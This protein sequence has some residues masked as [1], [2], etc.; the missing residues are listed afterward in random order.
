MKKTVLTLVILIN[1]FL[2]ISQEVTNEYQNLFN[3]AYAQHQQI[4]KGMLEAVSFTQTHFKHIQSS[5]LEGCSG[6]PL[7]SGVMGLTDDGKGYFRSNLS[8]VANLSGYSKQTI[9]N[10]PLINILSYA[11]AYAYLMDSL[12]I[13]TQEINRHDLILKSLSEIP[14]DHNVGN[15][16]ALNSFVY[17]VFDFLKSSSKQSFYQFPNHNI[18]MIEL[19]GENNLQVL[20]SSQVIISENSVVNNNN[21]VYES[22]NRTSQYTPAIWVATPSCNYSSRSGTVISAVTIHTIQGSYSGAISWAQNC[23]A[24]VSY[25]YVERSSDGQ[26]TQMVLEE[27]K[28][29]HVGN[30][31]PYTIGIE[32]EGYVSDASWYTEA[33][34]QSSANLV[35]DITDSGYGINPLRT[36]YGTATSGINVLGGCTKIKG[37]Q[38]YPNNSHTDPG[39]NWNWEK[40]YKLINN[41]PIVTSITTATGNLFDSGGNSSNYSNDER[42]MYLIEPTGATSIT[43]SFNSFSVESG[44]DYMYIYD[45][46]NT[47]APLMGVYTGNTIPSTLTSSGGQ[48]LLEFRSDCATTDIGWDLS[49]TS[50]IDA[51]T[52]DGT[53]PTTVINNLPNW[54]TVDFNSSFTDADENGGSGLHYKFYQIVDYNGTDWLSNAN[55]GFFYDEFD[56]TIQPEWTQQTALWS[57]SNAYL[58]C[59]DETESNSNIYASLNQ[60]DNDVYVYNWAGKIKG[61]GTNKRAGIHFMCSDPTLNQRG[62]SYMVYFRTDNDK[63]Q[64]YESVSNS[65]SLEADIDFTFNED[66]WYDLK[67][68]YD[69][70]TGEIKVFVD[71]SL[72]ASW[73]DATPISTGN[74]ISLRSGNCIYQINNFSVMH[75]RT[76]SETVGV[77]T[78]NEIRYQN[79]SPTSPSGLIKSMAIDSAGNISAIANKNVNLDWTNPI[80]IATVNDGDGADINTFTN[81]NSISAN[82]TISTDANSDISSY[83][84][85]IGTTSGG[86]DIVN[87]TDNWYNTS[88]THSGLSLTYGETYYVSIKAENGAGLFSNITTSNGHELITPTISPTANFIVPYTTLCA[89]DSMQLQNNSTDAETY[90]WTISSDAIITSPTAVNPYVKFINSG[91]FDISL[92]VTGPGGTDN[93]LQTI[94]VTVVEPPVASF[95]IADNIVSINSPQVT[96]TNTSVNANGY[97]WDY[98]DGSTSTDINPWHNYSSIGNY[99]VSLVAINGDCA[100]DTVQSTVSVVDDLNL[101]VNSQNINIYPNPTKDIVNIKLPEGDFTIKIMDLS[102]KIIERYSYI[103]TNESIDLSTLSSGIYYVKIESDHFVHIEELIKE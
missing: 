88:F 67:I 55:K 26:V 18:N 82:W 2:S 23:S 14:W 74:S 103:N 57:I 41:N 47:E 58:E 56:N 63:I 24:N 52:G 5:E 25:H 37:H 59:N 89:S 72:S 31:N 73:T 84:Y 60:N 16:Y 86:I 7:V 19:F 78:G 92:T 85:A 70:T 36:F 99:M 93:Q 76:S 39:I 65:I 35:R 68:V 71:N 44:W 96:F 51:I 80:D 3:I 61:V 50:V 43:L 28:A 1:L 100:N 20:A 33:M 42:L 69:K 29:W 48:I 46:I 15:N 32:H 12:N 81:N 83:W 90:S 98:S 8:F 6:I 66:Q 97:V 21:V 87:W 40:Y 95:T 11:S 27:D 13:E 49:W 102:G 64:I 22:Q 79:S 45:G 34:Y 10:D 53:A 75:N 54:Q 91:S 30:E 62:N 101:F 4:P 17:Q 94:A 77:N 38:H 9:K